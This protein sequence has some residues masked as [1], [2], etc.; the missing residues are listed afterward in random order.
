M[1]FHLNLCTKLSGPDSLP[2]IND[3]NEIISAKHQDTLLHE[4][5][6]W[7]PRDNTGMHRGTAGLAVL[8]YGQLTWD[9]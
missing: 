8:I 2:H 4:L 5:P 9:P 1:T 6:Q 7:L 3:Y